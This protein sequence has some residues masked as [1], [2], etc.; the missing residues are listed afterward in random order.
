[1]ISIH[2]FPSR[3]FASAA[4]SFSACFDLGPRFCGRRVRPSLSR[5]SN[6]L[7]ALDVHILQA[8][9]LFKWF[10]KSLFGVTISKLTPRRI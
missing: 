9:H 5:I 7:G 10:A 2:F 8:K 4:G 3:R 6:A 1:M